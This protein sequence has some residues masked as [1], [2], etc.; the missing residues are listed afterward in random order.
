M[1]RKRTQLILYEEYEEHMHEKLS[2]V[3]TEEIACSTARPAR[4]EI[5]RQSLLIEGNL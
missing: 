3:F 5:D 1:V 2:C 4:S